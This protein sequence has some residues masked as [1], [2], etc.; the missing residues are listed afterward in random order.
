MKSRIFTLLALT[1]TAGLSA[2]PVLNSNWA[3]VV[4]VTGTNTIYAPQS[5]ATPASGANATWNYGNLLTGGNGV[6]TAPVDLYPV[7]Q[8]PAPYNTGYPP[9]STAASYYES[10]GMPQITYYAKTANQ[11]GLT[12]YLSGSTTIDYS[13]QLLEAV[14]PMSLGDTETEDFVI[15]IS[16]N[17]LEG[18]QTITYMGY[19]TLTLPTGTYTNVICIK[20]EQDYGFGTNGITYTWYKP[21]WAFLLRV[22]IADNG[23]S[24]S[25]A[26]SSVPTGVA[27]NN[28]VTVNTFPNPATDVVFVSSPAQKYNLKVYSATGALVAQEQ[29]DNSDKKAFPL[30]VNTLSPGMYLLNI[31]VDGLSTTQ[32]FIKL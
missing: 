1:F 26:N 13:P 28:A 16:G 5:F 21:G 11:L 24:V 22:A 7:S 30:D 14:F 25:Y 18:N 27:E 9:G 10:N 32:R 15:D 31:E 29:V 4:G 12:G 23:T 3:F 20:G 6:S 2:Q 17:Q 8:L 19:G